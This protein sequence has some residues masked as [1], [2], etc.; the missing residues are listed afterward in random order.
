MTANRFVATPNG[1]TGAVALRA[2]VAADLPA[3]ITS[4]TNG[5][6]ATATAA[7]AL[8]T[9]CPVGQAARGVDTSWNARD[10]FAGAAP[11]PSPASGLSALQINSRSQVPAES[12][13][14]ARILPIRTRSTF[15]G[16]RT[17]QARSRGT[18]PRSAAR[19]HRIGVAEG[20]TAGLARVAGQDALAFDYV[21]QRYVTLNEGTKIVWP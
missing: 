16:L 9:E 19:G 4:N 14:L 10:C 21:D 18:D 11:V 3:T 1:S 8:G 17:S 12:Q 13:L 7:A 15:L 2:I 20:S 6:A 5:N